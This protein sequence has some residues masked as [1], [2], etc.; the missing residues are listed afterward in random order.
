MT[1]SV[2]RRYL[3]ALFVCLA[4]GGVAVAEESHVTNVAAAT[5]RPVADSS[6][7]TPADRAIRLN[8]EAVQLI[9]DGK[10]EEGKTKILAALEIDP[11]NPTVLY[12]YAGIC[13][14][15]G[16]PKDAID[17][18]ERAVK[19]DPADLTL[20]NR[21]AES[22]FA[23]SNLEQAVKNYER[24]VAADPKFDQALFRLGTLYGMQQ[25]W[26]QAESTLRKALELNKDDARVLANLG[27]VLVLQEKY[28]EAVGML[29]SA[30]AKKPNP[31]AEMSLAIAYEGL[32]NPTKALQHY[33]AAKKLGLAD[34]GLEKRIADL[35]E[36]QQ[37]SE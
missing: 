23:N 28:K 24:I 17:A 14:T 35:R 20:V 30:R 8:E 3:A 33:E 4:H 22:H 13:L 31:E 11:N 34:E 9:F 25:R 37:P 36:K 21:L 6:S 5:S 2:Q 27:S 12:N 1:Y 32:K 29:E 15:E 26:P 16:K 10:Q 7:L 18:M 19:A